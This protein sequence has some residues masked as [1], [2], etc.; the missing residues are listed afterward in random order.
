[1]REKGGNEKEVE[2][3]ITNGVLEFEGNKVKEAPPYGE[4][5]A[6]LA[7]PSNIMERNIVDEKRGKNSAEELDKRQSGQSAIDERDGIRNW[8]EDRVD[9]DPNN[10]GMAEKRESGNGAGKGAGKFKNEEECSSG[11]NADNN[12]ADDKSRGD[13]AGKELNSVAGKSQESQAVAS[14]E[15]GKA[16][17]NGEVDGERKRKKKYQ[18]GAF[19]AVGNQLNDQM[20]SDRYGQRKIL[21]YMEY[22]NDEVEEADMNYNDKEEEENQRQSVNAGK[23]GGEREGEGKGERERERVRSKEVFSFLFS[24]FFSREKRY[25][26]A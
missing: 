19:V 12:F 3:P 15:K 14:G 1:M 8:L 6:G 13:V 24:F 2:I 23:S 26:S 17:N 7:L 21:Q 5:T 18:G 16:G 25:I 10:R 11:E 4:D 22:S 9:A 20:T